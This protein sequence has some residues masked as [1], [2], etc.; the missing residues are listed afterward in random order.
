MGGAF[1]THLSREMF[2]LWII[3]FLLCFSAFYL[4]LLPA[5]AGLLVHGAAG[6][7]RSLPMLHLPTASHAVLLSCAIGLAS[8]AI[9]LYRPEICLQTRRLLLNTVVAGLLAFPAVLLVSVITSIDVSFLFGQDALWPVKIFLTWI[10]LL[11]LP[12]LAFRAILRSGVLTR[13]VV[14]VGASQSAARAGAAINTRR[15]GFF[16]VVGAL[17][18]GE[19]AALT[20][21]R[22]RAQRVWG[23]LI[24]SDA[25]PAVA[26]VRLAALRAHGAEV[27]DDVDFFERH[28]R[29]LDL[30]H[31]RPDWLEGAPGLVCG[32]LQAGVRRAG[33]IAISLLL[34]LLTLPLLGFTALAIKLDSPGPVLYRQARIGLGGKVFTL[35]KLRS[36]RADAEAGGP[37]WAVRRDSRVT[38]VGAFIRLTRIDELPQ[39]VNVL[40]GEMSFVGPRPER[41]TFV[42]QLAEAIPFYHDRARV[43]PGVTGWAQVSFP[44][45]ASVEDA[46]QKLS[47]DL[48]Y[49]KHRSLFFD[50]LIILATIRVILFQEGAR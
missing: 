2:V 33:E 50:A 21:A 45:G 17:S 38:R 22:L 16:R 42:K 34:L 1:S 10:L 31:L 32:R 36:M 43:K 30:A 3:E 35:Y 39:L 48:Y 29:R 40:R 8:L 47:Y 9:G 4:L 44:Y 37:A 13:N 15:R 25:R 46:R 23:V 14:I 28:L 24:T 7:D 5:D 26:S 27:F 18:A 12:R 19:L 49:V 11:F 41:P 20:P 6:W